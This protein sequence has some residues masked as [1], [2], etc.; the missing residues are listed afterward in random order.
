MLAAAMDRRCSS[1]GDY[2][3][4][5]VLRRTTHPRALTRRVRVQVSLQEGMR[6]FAKWFYEYYGAAGTQYRADEMA[7]KPLR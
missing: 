6:K 4:I 5:G 1:S 7:Y 3:R 2:G